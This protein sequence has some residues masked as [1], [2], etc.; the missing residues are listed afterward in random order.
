[1]SSLQYYKKEN[2]WEGGRTVII[3]NG[4]VFEQDGRFVKKDLYI[5]KDRIADYAGGEEI[6]A[7]GLYVIPGLTDIHFH[8]CV[9]YDFC[10]GTEEALRKMA[11]Y[12]LEN[13]I[14][15]ICP[16]SMT[17][18]EEQLTE[19]F[20]N[21]A[22]YDNKNGAELVGINMEGPFVSMEKK[23]AQNPKYITKPDADMFFR[24]QKVSGGLVKLV[25]IAPEE[26]GAMEFIEKVSENVRVS[27]AHTVADYDIA[28]EAFE[29]GASHVTHLYNAM[30]PYSHRAP[31]VVGAASDSD[32][33]M[34][35][36]IC[37][38]IHIHPATVRAT[39]KM[40]GD[41]RIIFIS[42]SMRACG[43]QDGQYMLGGLEVTV[44]GKKATLTKEGNIA[45]SVTNL[46]NCV[47]T[48]VREM[49]IPLESAV[50]CA[51]VNPAKAIGIYD[52]YGSLTSGKTANIVL[53]NENLEI[54]RII[55]KGK[56][57]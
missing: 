55:Q 3:K 13:G 32:N 18:S 9:G 47:R 26:K 30:P 1:V 53:L 15:T 39:F 49:Q 21:A 5:E 31:G 20:Q 27:L 46:M 42:D 51:A 28:R 48:A 22:E 23:G 45:G 57:I 36:L 16:A 24:L 56:T 38:G 34:V 40:F 4:K 2:V 6:D 50:K 17:F 35:E 44:Q 8:G 54:V 41:D 7:E 10:D 19:I 14:T 29:K 33:V 37:D 52:K 43:L 25:D 12:Q 11:A